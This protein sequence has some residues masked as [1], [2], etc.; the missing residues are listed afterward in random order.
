M[1]RSAL[2]CET[3]TEVDG[4][5]LVS[6]YVKEKKIIKGPKLLDSN[7][8]YLGFCELPITSKLFLKRNHLGADAGLQIWK[9]R[10]NVLYQN[11]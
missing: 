11:L 2:P 8:V 6:Y 1:T 5:K 3:D 4:T 9:Y 10:L 7:L